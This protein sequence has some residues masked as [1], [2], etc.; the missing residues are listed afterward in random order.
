MP[1]SFF[2]KKSNSIVFSLIALPLLSLAQIDTV[3]NLE[4]ITETHVAKAIV[5]RNI[6]A[7][8]QLDGLKATC[9]EGSNIP[10]TYHT[11]TFTAHQ[12]IDIIWKRY[13]TLNLIQ[14]LGGKIVKT[15][16]IYSRATQNL[17]YA[18]EIGRKIKEGQIVFFNIHLFQGL[19]NMVTALEVTCINESE[20]T[21]DF[22]YIQDGNTEGTQKIKLTSTA[23]GTT[24]IEHTTYYRSK[25]KFRDNHLYPHFHAKSIAELHDNIL[26]PKMKKDKHKSGVQ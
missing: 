21:I 13:A 17:I 10:H 20:K 15:G 14:S 24:L 4:R 25:S 12:P 6:Q 23:A 3:I 9:L 1:F 16:F 2:F 22:C 26:K 5:A 8:K 18:D 11:K 19:L 7:F